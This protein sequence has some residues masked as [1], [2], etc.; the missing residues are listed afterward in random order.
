MPLII[1]NIFQNNAKILVYIKRS[2]IISFAIAGIYGLYLMHLNGMNPYTS[3]LAKTFSVTDAANIYSSL[4]S[5]ISFSNAGKI[6]STMGHPMTWA[7]YLCFIIVVFVLYAFREKSKAYLLILG[8]SV[9]NLLISGVRTGIAALIIGFIYFIIR[10]RQIKIVLSGIALVSLSYFVIN[11]NKDLSNLF[12][13][14]TDVSG[15]KSNVEG[16][17]I[18]MRLVQLQGAI[19]EISGSEMVGKGYGWNDY[20]ISKY[21]DHPILLAFES[22]IF[23]V[24]CNSGIIGMF[25]WIIF[26]ISLFKLHRNYLKNR[27]DIFLM[28]TFLIIYIAY[29]I[30]TGEY[31]YIQIFSVYYVFLIAS[32]IKFTKYKIN[33]NKEDL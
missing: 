11:S 26:F 24:L 9:F 3:F 2:L 13:S 7:L 10:N 17:S 16:S 30:G 28:D 1:W 19:S 6:Q 4:G 32:L 18:L 23:V 14:F 8:L 20:Y 5:R 31:G 33:Q 29:S 12:K 25:I 21:G 27:Q 15:T 22:L